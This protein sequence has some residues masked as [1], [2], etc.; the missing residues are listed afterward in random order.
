LE[1]RATGSLVEIATDG[2]GKETTVITSLISRLGLIFVGSPYGQNLKLFTTEGRGG[3]PYG[4]GTL[5]GGDGLRQPAENELGTARKL[6]VRVVKAATG[7][8][9][10]CGRRSVSA[11]KPDAV[12][13]AL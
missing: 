1:G 6:G 5:A 10:G 4:P 12:S 2:G 7:I 9:G 8:Q 11:K 3:S 13:G